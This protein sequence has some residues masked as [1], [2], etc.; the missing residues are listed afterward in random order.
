MSPSLSSTLILPDASNAE[1]QAVLPNLRPTSIFHRMPWKPPI[2]ISAQGIYITLENG[3]IL[4][5]GTG[6]PTVACIGNG[7]PAPVKAMKDQLD[8]LSC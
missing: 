1:I 4:I 2:A 5:D 3:E 8:K 7:H 6:G